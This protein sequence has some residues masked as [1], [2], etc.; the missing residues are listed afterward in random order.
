M[1]RLK[2]IQP[3]DASGKAKELLGAVQS[4]L[5][6]VPNLAKVLANSTAA[7]EAY[8]GFSGALG[9]GV[10]SAQLREEIALAVAQTNSCDYCLAAHAAIGKMAGLDAA[11]IAS[12]RNARSANGKENAA[13]SFAKQLVQDRGN[14]TDAQL[15][16]LRQA[17]FS[18]G[19]VAEIVANVAL[20]IFTNYFNHVAQTDV[21]FPRVD[22][23]SHNTSSVQ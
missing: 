2:A 7:L 1:S 3:E 18:D 20:N 8:L 17:G 23:A 5:G 10:L 11:A 15:Q 6:L 9:Q 13:L 21:D 12:S 4:K 16:A 14:T 22:H 19:E